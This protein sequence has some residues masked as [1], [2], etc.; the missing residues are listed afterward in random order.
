MVSENAWGLS[1]STLL[2]ASLIL[3]AAPV[4][5]GSCGRATRQYDVDQ[6]V[7][8]SV[9]RTMCEQK[10]SGYVVLSTAT[11]TVSPA[12]APTSIDESARRSLLERNEKPSVLPPVDICRSIR[13]ID[14]D[15]INRYFEQSNLDMHERWTAFY[16]RFA[17]ASGAMNI[18]LPGYSTQ[19]DIAVVQIGT[20][21]GETCG[22]GSFWVLRRIAG[23]WQ[24]DVVL[25]GWQS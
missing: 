6:D 24:V 23:R 22:G 21:C 16:E 7:V 13:L 15:E 11:S 19:G 18:S 3:L 17:D 8:S 12:F 2:R 1:M 14:G 4:V 10:T 9:V 5:L 25:P 20:S